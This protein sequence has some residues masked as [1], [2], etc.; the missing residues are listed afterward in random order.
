MSYKTVL[1]TIDDVKLLKI[2]KIS[3]ARGSLTFVESHKH[4]PFDVQRIFYLYDIAEGE[5]RGAHAHRE[6]HH[7]LIALNGSFDVSIDDGHNKSIVH[8]DKPDYG[9]YVPPMIWDAELNFSKGA[10]C[11]VLASMPY[12]ESDYIR[13]YDEFLQL[14]ARNS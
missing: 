3:D 9:L 14:T 6:C 12:T 13:S 7:L 10:I 1:P 5:S 2:P 4:F 8:L 11:L